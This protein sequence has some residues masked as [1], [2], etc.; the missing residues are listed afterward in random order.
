[1]GS[2]SIGPPASPYACIQ[3]G[4]TSDLVYT[5]SAEWRARPVGLS[6]T[7]ELR[8]NT[9]WTRSSLSTRSCVIFCVEIVER[10]V[11]PIEQHPQHFRLAAAH[12]EHQVLVSNRHSG[13]FCQRRYC[14][15]ADEY[16]ATGERLPEK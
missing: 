6:I 14:P 3:R 12:L 15:C 4:V 1:V 2:A 16:R 8:R 11:V 5:P 9:S 10:R 7:A 13:R